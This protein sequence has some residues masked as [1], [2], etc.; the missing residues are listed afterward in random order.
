MR[1]PTAVIFLLVMML[2]MCGCQTV[3]VTKKPITETGV[4]LPADR[5]ATDDES[6]ASDPCAI[7]LHDIEGTMLLFYAVNKRLPD[8]LEDLKPL[9]DFGSQLQLVCP[10]TGQAYQYDP[11]GLMSAGRSKRIIVWDSTAAHHGNRFCILMPYTPPGA[12][13]SL[14]VVAVPEADFG[15]YVPAIQ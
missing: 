12:A 11:R 5:P 7:R 6:V 4:A 15:T 3:S 8:S 9:A 10:A 14:E 1:T 2:L 13:M